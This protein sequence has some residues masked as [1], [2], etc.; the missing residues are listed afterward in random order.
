MLR[1][2]AL[3]LSVALVAVILLVPAAG[4]AEDV[5]L[6]GTVTP[7]SVGI[8][9]SPTVLDLSGKAGET[10]TRTFT[11][12]NIG[13]MA[14]NLSLDAFTADVGGKELVKHPWE[15]TDPAKAHIVLDTPLFTLPTGFT[16]DVVTFSGSQV[17]GGGGGAYEPITGPVTVATLSPSGISGDAVSFGVTLITHRDMP[18]PAGVSGTITFTATP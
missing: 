10:I 18:S 5:T 16:V 11:V 14:V 6:T 12:T 8:S 13:G 3:V 15:I 9:I 7:Q 1:K 4:M 2:L 17:L